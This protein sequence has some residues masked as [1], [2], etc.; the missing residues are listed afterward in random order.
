MER[1][2]GGFGYEPQFEGMTEKEVRELKGILN[3]FL[4]AY[5]E[6]GKKD[7]SYG[8]LKECYRNELPDWEEEKIEQLTEETL[9]CIKENDDNFAA[10]EE[11]AAG[12][13]SSEKWF[14][15]K[16]KDAAANM[17][18]QEYGQ[19]LGEI[20]RALSMAN[21]QMMR[22][23][24]TKAGEISLNYNLDGFIA[25]QHHV[26]TFNANAA[27]KKSDYVAEVKVPGEGEA[28]G[29]NSFD[30]VVRDRH[31]GTKKPVQQYQVKYGAD[32]KATI[33]MLKE[34]N[35]NNQRILV[36]S[37]QV[38]EVQAAFPTKTVTDR[39]EMGEVSSTPLTKAEAKKMQLEAQETGEV[40]P[41]DYNTFQTKELALQIGRNAG[42]A[43]LQA[44]A[45]TTGFT[46][47][48]NALK[49]E[50]IDADEVVAA[51]IETG[52]D[53]GIK[54]AVAGAVKVGSERGII[55]LIPRGTP[56]GII[57]GIA[58][59][60]IENVK[61]LAKVAKGELTMSEA[62][63]KMGRTATTMYYGMAWG[64]AGTGIGA[65]ALSWVPIVGP[66]IGGVAGGMV[67]YMAGSKFGSAVY[68][69]AKKVASKAKEVVSN[70]A[71][72]VKDVGRNILDGIKS[73]GSFIFG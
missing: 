57:S 73:F 23:V 30:C 63:D 24:T 43:G 18:V 37:D 42:F 72:K 49:G 44:A 64:A 60:A 51:A 70:V 38:A 35:Y 40:A 9:S 67:G 27:L 52:A 46:L 59:N 47:A 62:L 53:T 29:L 50:Q 15:D 68:E 31:A 54:A 39:I 5:K 22:T 36:P 6:R 14:A 71:E 7:G 45:V 11:A 20:D 66:V 41:T 28:Y 61:I 12:G 8:W 55:S 58:C 17:T 56:M 21:S 33:R 1:Q 48:A 16:V 26:N 13:K 3:L 2:M 69:T 32:A 25:E 10:A 19:K 4:K 65:L 34:G